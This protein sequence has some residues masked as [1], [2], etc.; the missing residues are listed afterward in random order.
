VVDVLVQC[1]AGNPIRLTASEAWELSRALWRLGETRGI[2]GGIT[3]SA[4][5]LESRRDGRPVAFDDE[6]API[7]RDP[8]E[9]LTTT[10]RLTGNL[11]DLACTVQ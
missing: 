4:A 6:D 10:Q 2:R 8:L 1:R 11:V 3:F 9:W 7:L 5:L